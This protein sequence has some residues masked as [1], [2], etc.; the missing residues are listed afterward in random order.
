MEQRF[1][2]FRTNACGATGA[3]SQG[4]AVLL[5]KAMRRLSGDQDGTLIVP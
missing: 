5:T 1:A 4:I 3:T 2:P